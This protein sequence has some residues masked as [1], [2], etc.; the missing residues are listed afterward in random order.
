MTV[1]KAEFDSYGDSYN[2]EVNSALCLPG[3]NVDFFTRVKAAYI[4]DVVATRFPNPA[5]VRL[6]DVGCGVGNMTSLLVGALGHVAGADVSQACIATAVKNAPGVEYVIYDGTHLPY[7]PASLDVATAIC[8]FHHVPPSDRLPLARDIRRVL[9]P[10]GLLM[11]FEHNPRN[12]LTMRIV[13]RCEFDKGAILLQRADTE[14]LLRSAG[15]QNVSTRFILTIP[16]AGAILRR[17]D[18]MFSRLSLG[19][20]YYTMGSAY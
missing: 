13:N 16:A 10:Q 14:A 17:L 2:R 8:V 11:I 4:R 19:A 9:R 7:P 6:L 3:L 15:F 18:Q 12:P 5:Q 20:Q 1:P